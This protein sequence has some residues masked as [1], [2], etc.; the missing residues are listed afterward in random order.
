MVVP[1]SGV[2]MNLD[3]AL[4]AS[5]FWSQKQ[6]GIKEIGA[7]LKIPPAGVDDRERFPRTCRQ[8]VGS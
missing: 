5:A 7:G 1:V 8:R 3:I 2:D 4:N 6:N